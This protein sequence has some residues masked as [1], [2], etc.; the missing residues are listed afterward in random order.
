MVIRIPLA[1]G[2]GLSVY[3]IAMAMTVYDEALS[4]AFQ[5]IMGSIITGLSLLAVCVVGSPMLIARIWAR[6]RRWWWVSVLLLVGGLGALALSWHP[7]LRISVKNPDTGQMVDSFQ[8]ALAVGGWFATLF[9]VAF[10]PFA[11]FYKD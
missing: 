6:W 3:M 9:G 1:F 8:P 10:C 7:S 11:G 2:V 5:P 4:L